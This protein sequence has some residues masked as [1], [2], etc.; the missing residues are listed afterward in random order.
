MSTWS[1]CGEWSLIQGLI[2]KNQTQ[3]FIC[4][5]RIY[6]EPNISFCLNRCILKTPLRYA[7]ENFTIHGITA[8]CHWECINLSSKTSF[9]KIW[10]ILKTV[11]SKFFFTLHN[12]SHTCLASNRC[13]IQTYCVRHFICIFS[14]KVN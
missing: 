7:L 5:W 9:L 14:V 1:K 6:C 4:I 12:L 3:Y 13:F 10:D 2:E 8:L 11:E